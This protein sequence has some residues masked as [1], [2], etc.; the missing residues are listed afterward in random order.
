MKPADYL[1]LAQEHGATVTLNGDKLKLSGPSPLPDEIMDGLREHKAEIIELL[2]I[3][4][5]RRRVLA[6]FEKNATAK[7]AYLTDDQTDPAHVIVTVALRTGET[8]ELLIPRAN[9]DPF[10][11]LDCM[12]SFEQGISQ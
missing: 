9:Y 1:R 7:R 5:R 2:H 6:M 3:E 4:E 10:L 8:G 12:K 11:F